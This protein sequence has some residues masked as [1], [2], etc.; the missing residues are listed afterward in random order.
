ML[1]RRVSPKIFKRVATVQTWFDGSRNIQ[2]TSEGRSYSACRYIGRIDAST[3]P[4]ILCRF[5]TCFT[6]QAEHRA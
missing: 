3:T 4:E 5:L 6:S 2:H 1:L